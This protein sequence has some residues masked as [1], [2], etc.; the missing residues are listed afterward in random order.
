MA[1][2]HDRA[3]RGRTR[4]GWLD[5]HHTYS[6][7]GFADPSR[8][9]FRS[10]RVLNED[11]VIPGAG[12]AAHDHAD[13]EILTYVIS[14]ALEHRDSLGTVSTIPA[15]EVQWMSAGTGV[16]HSE[17]NASSDAPAHFLQIWIV[18]AEAGGQP[19]YAQMPVDPAAVR[20]RYHPIVQPS[21]APGASGDFLSINQDAII[22]LARLE[23]GGTLDYGF[24]P[25]RAG[26]LQVVDG[27]VTV[28]GE[29]LFAGDGLETDDGDTLTVEAMTDCELLLLDLR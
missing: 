8:M 1:R 6:F 27:L 13:M 16:T 28:E 2:I 12:F 23:D 9:G 15:G 21:G 5:S 14:G 20:N 18:P 10:L 29:R 26:F 3:L 11:R 4:T 7:G 25:G 22:H 24:S 17:M 19:S